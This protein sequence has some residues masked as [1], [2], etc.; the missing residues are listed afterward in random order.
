MPVSINSVAPPISISTPG[1]DPS[2]S[3][4]VIASI[5]TC[6]YFRTNARTSSSLLF[7][8]R[9]LIHSFMSLHLQPFE[10]VLRDHELLVGRDYPCRNRAARRANP[11]SVPRF[12]SDV[13]RD[14]RPCRGAAPPFA[15][16][17]RMLAD[18]PSKHDRVEPAEG[19]R[20][21]AEL[22]RDPVAKQIDRVGRR[23]IVTFEQR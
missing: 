18:P 7:G 21:R 20:E 14:A 13:E 11:R 1:C 2:P 3:M 15:S 8:G 23:R 17:R 5:S 4:R 12:R 16:G 6:V 22:A 9:L 10:R 19:G